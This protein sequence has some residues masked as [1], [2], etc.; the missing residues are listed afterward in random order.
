MNVFVEIGT[1][2]NAV[3]SAAWSQ[4]GHH[5][6]FSVY[7][8]DEVKIFDELTHRALVDVT[9][10]PPVGQRGAKETELELFLISFMERLIDV[11]SF[12]RTKFTGRLY[13]VTGDT[14]HPQTA[15]SAMNAISL[16]LLQSGFPLR[17]TV[18]AICTELEGVPITIAI[19]VTHPQLSGSDQMACIPSVFSIYTGQSKLADSAR[20]TK[21]F[22]PADLS[23]ILAVP[24]DVNELSNRSLYRQALDLVDVMLTQLASAQ[25]PL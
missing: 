20:G 18:A 11:K 3:G 12:P 25:V 22:S 17:A 21:G 7:G 2:C 5:V 6:F 23:R 24:K 9:V 14:T 4:S 10:A 8:P 13:I 16:A 15:A 19:D 1:D